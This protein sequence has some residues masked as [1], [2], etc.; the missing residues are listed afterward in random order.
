MNLTPTEID[1]LIIFNAAEFARRRLCLPAHEM[2]S[3]GGLPAKNSL[4]FDA[5][6]M[7]IRT[8]VSRVTPPAWGDRTTLGALMSRSAAV[9]GSGSKT[10]MPAPAIRCAS[11]ASAR[12]S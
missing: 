1:R 10:S 9:G 4:T 7:A 3:A 11:S 12:A 8:S 5:A 2:T 6:A